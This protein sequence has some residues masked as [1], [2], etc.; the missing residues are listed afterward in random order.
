[1]QTIPG[2]SETSQLFSF[3]AFCPSAL[4]VTFYLTTGVLRVSAK[5]VCG[6]LCHCEG[7]IFLL[8]AGRKTAMCCI[9]R[10]AEELW[11]SSQARTRRNSAMT[12]KEETVE[13]LKSGGCHRGSIL[14]RKLF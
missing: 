7:L 13:E 10:K 1:V 9:A 5:Q 4:L 2:S 11:E 6:L 14:L 8:S 12:K 3:L